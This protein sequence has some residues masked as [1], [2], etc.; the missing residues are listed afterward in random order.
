MSGVDRVIASGRRVDA[1]NGFQL[2]VGVKRCMTMVAHDNIGACCSIDGVARVAAKYDIVS[3]L[4]SDDICCTRIRCLGEDVSQLACGVELRSTGIPQDDELR[5]NCPA[6]IRSGDRVT[7]GPAHHNA[8]CT[9]GRN[10]IVATDG[11]VRGLHHTTRNSAGTAVARDHTLALITQN[12]G[13]AGTDR[14]A[15]VSGSSNHNVRT[16]AKRD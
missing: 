13:R 9:S 3:V 10:L 11:I 14:H 12:R 4:Q 2:T 8:D 7:A 15:V 5:R 6:R 1:V 16:V